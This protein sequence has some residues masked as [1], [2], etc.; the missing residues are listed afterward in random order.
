MTLMPRRALLGLGLVTGTGLAV[1][2]CSPQPGTS[3]SAPSGEGAGEATA[4]T[5]VHAITRAPV[6][7]A[8][9]RSLGADGHTG[10]GG[11]A[12]GGGLGGAGGHGGH[13]GQGRRVE[14]RRGAHA[15]AQFG[16]ARRGP[17]GIDRH[18][19][20]PTDQAREERDDGVR[21][22]RHLERDGLPRRGARTQVGGH[23]GHARGQFGVAQAPPGGRVDERGRGRMG[24]D[25]GREQ[26]RRG[27]GDLRRRADGLGPG[28]GGAGRQVPAGG[29]EGPEPVTGRREQ[30]PLHEIG[31]ERACGVGGSVG[32]RLPIVPR[33]DPAAPGDIIGV[34]G[35]QVGEQVG[36]H[37]TGRGRGPGQG[38]VDAVDRQPEVVDRALGEGVPPQRQV[39]DP[40]RLIEDLE[41]E[42]GADQRCVAGDAPGES[43]QLLRAKPAVP[44]HPVQPCRDVGDELAEG[45]AGRDADVHRQHV[46]DAGRRERGRPDPVHQG[47]A[48]DDFAVSAEPGHGH[49]VG[50]GDDVGPRHAESVGGVIEFGGAHGEPPAPDRPGATGSTGGA[51]AANGA[52]AAGAADRGRRRRRQQR[53]HR[54]RLLRGSVCAQPELPIARIRRRAFVVPF[55]GGDPRGIGEPRGRHRAP[56]AAGREDLQRAPREQHRAVAVDEHMV[57]EQ[58]PHDAVFAQHPQPLAVQRTRAEADARGEVVAHRADRLRP[59]PRQPAQVS[60]LAP[61]AVDLVRPQDGVEHPGA[62]VGVDPQR[63]AGCL[64]DGLLD[65]TRQ[66]RRV[67]RCARLQLHR[68]PDRVARRGVGTR[69]EVP[70]HHA[71]LR[72]REY[73]RGSGGGRLR[74]HASFFNVVSRLSSD[75]RPV[76]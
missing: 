20:P 37:P 46:D 65:R 13:G 30:H 57:R 33:T 14:H 45:P 26:F 11:H 15:G 56:V 72:A 3:T 38:T 58:A 64:G 68:L 10:G 40:A 70:V 52:V 31:D 62:A 47:D 16:A 21:A 73:P 5:H 54:A 71:L 8:R 50:G 1:A 23:R 19:D 27:R 66:Q 74:V 25:D 67:D 48:D 2:A 55:G 4:I 36:G 24:G 35:A 44:A 6:D 22:A 49:R 28:L 17:G 41:V 51:G 43:G 61:R 42:F 9:R 18:G 76:S 75:F 12:G 53:A 60:D 32:L 7:G 59:R 63:P 69:D 34:V 39:A 29:A